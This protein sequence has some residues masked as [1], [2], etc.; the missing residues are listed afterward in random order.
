MSKI[1]IGEDEYETADLL[2]YQQFNLWLYEL[3]LDVVDGNDK[4][5]VDVVNNRI[6]KCQT[7][8]DWLRAVDPD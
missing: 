5:L 6:T 2:A 4:E 7:N 8:I 3:V 1:S